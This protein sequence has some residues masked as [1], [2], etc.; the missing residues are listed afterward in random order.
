ME[1]EVDSEFDSEAEAVGDGSDDADARL[2]LNSRVHSLWSFLHIY[3]SD[4]CH[5]N[6]F[7]AA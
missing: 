3:D 7:L 5:D 1:A 2:W 6:A 4:S